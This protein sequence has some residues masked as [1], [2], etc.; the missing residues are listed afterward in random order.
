MRVRKE[1]VWIRG[2]LEQLGRLESIKEPTKLYSDNEGAVAL[3]HNPENY[4]RT[5]HIDVAAHY[6]RELHED[7]VVNVDHVGTADMAADCLTK[8]LAKNKHTNNVGNLRLR[9]QEAMKN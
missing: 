8:P 1:T 4:Q 2:L 6:I 9:K 5:K 7:G 3:V